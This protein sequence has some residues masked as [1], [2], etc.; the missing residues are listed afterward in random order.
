MA[1]TEQN[2]AICR[3]FHVNIM[4][5]RFDEAE[6][7]LAPDVVWWVQGNMAVSGYHHGRAAVAALFTPLKALPNGIVF[8]FGAA[9]A[10]DERVSSEMVAHAKITDTISYNNTYHFLFRVKDGLIVEGK[11]YLDTKITSEFLGQ[12]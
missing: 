7:L 4:E 5:G 10:E 3:K 8:T 11:E 9:T 1:N 12:G 2:K 6:A